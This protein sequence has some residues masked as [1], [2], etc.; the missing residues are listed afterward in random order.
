MRLQCPQQ[1]RPSGNS[2]V[3]PRSAM[4]VR[5]TSKV[6]EDLYEKFFTN[7]GW[8][9]KRRCFTSRVQAASLS[10][11]GSPAQPIGTAQPNQLVCGDPP[12][13]NGFVRLAFPN[14]DYH[15]SAVMGAQSR[16]ESWSAMP[17][18]LQQFG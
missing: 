4:Q 17:N 18:G 10:L 2:Q 5:L 1:I 3:G 8:V 14:S 12:N 7:G 9:A 13:R 6:G 16:D 15:V 11:T